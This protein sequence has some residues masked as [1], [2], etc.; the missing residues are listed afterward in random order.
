MWLVEGGKKTGI[1][2]PV[3]RDRMLAELVLKELKG[4]RR[5]VRGACPE[6]TEGLMTGVKRPDVQEACFGSDCRKVNV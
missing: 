5:D 2:R 4:E 1:L 6:G 3:K